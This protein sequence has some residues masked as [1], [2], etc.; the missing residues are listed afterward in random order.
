[1]KRA[2]K[3]SHGGAHRSMGD[4]G[5]AAQQRW[6]ASRCTSTWAREGAREWSGKVQGALGVRLAFYR[7]RGRVGEAATSGKRRWL[8]ALTPLMAGQG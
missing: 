5:K 3:R 1:M 6:R 7:G 2:T 8:M 4:G